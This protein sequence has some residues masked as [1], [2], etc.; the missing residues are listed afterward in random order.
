M[1]QRKVSCSWCHKEFT[2]S[3][4]LAKYCCHECKMAFRQIRKRISSLDSIRN[5]HEELETQGK[6]FRFPRP[7]EDLNGLYGL[8]E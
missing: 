8:G 5:L 6:D 4:P 7:N 1:P 2:T 3:R